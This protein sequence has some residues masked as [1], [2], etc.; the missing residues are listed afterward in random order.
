MLFCKNETIT[1][2]GEQATNTNL[3]LAQTFA[4]ERAALLSNK[5]D[6]N[7]QYKQSYG[8]LNGFDYSVIDGVQ[9]KNTLKINNGSIQ[10]Y[11]YFGV[12]QDAVEFSFYKPKTLSYIFIYA[13]FDMS[14]HP[15]IF[16][17]RARN[18]GSRDDT[19][20]MQQMN[21]SAQKN[22]V[23]QVLL[24]KAE[25]TSKGITKVDKMF[26][27][28]EEFDIANGNYIVRVDKYNFPLSGAEKVGR[29]DGKMTA[30]TKRETSTHMIGPEV[31]TTAYTNIN[32]R[33]EVIK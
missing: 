30:T 33:N 26:T 28:T 23:C 8:V 5:R 13:E 20:W 10:A 16:S 22:G 9:S 6:S 15:N 7:L 12:L 4:K 27:T 25:L 18:N 2:L 32:I 3:I 21:L 19:A 31:A 29:I 1:G 17:I 24:Y 11:G 14:V